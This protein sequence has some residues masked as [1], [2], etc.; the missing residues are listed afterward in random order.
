[1]TRQSGCILA[2]L[3]LAGCSVPAH[4]IAA[5]GP[6]LPSSGG[7]TQLAAQIDADAAKSDHE[8]D[9]QVRTQLAADARGAADACIAQAPQSA[10]CVFG[11]ALALGLDARA[12]PAHAAATLKDMLATL[13]QAEALDPAYKD[14]GP[15]RVQA[16]V[17][18]R[19]PPWPL[20]PGDAEQAVG[21]ARRAVAL[22]PAY[23][24]N[25]LA[26]AEAQSKAGS[27]GDAAAS[28]TRARDAARA[29]PEGPDRN[30]WLQQA[31]QHA[32]HSP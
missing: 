26:L 25:W 15:A 24:P 17:L 10:V 12:H 3:I 23:P 29:L 32:G 5:P 8:G 18:A 6:A 27:M 14:A 4:R 28:Y 19:A 31:E 22:R 13:A 7:V 11:S 1:M 20:G 30:D 16:L 9:A 2:A 21:A